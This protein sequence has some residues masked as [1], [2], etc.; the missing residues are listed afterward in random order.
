LNKK[1][2]LKGEEEERG[3]KVSVKKFVER[4]IDLIKK[5]IPKY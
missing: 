2:R 4:K 1:G 3:T 5:Y